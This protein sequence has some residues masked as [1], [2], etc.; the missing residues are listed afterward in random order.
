VLDDA[1][2]LELLALGPKRFRIGRRTDY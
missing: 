2:A 1:E